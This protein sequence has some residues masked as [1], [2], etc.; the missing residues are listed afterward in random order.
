MAAMA[1]GGKMKLAFKG[2]P[3]PTPSKSKTLIDLETKFW[4]SMV[5]QDTDAALE[6]LEEPALMVSSH[7][8]MKFDHAGYRKMAEQ[9]SMVVTAFELSDVEA[10]F[11]NDK[12]AILTYR[13]RQEVAARG[14]GKSV[15]QEMNDTS[16]WVKTRDG[17]KCVMHTE[18]PACAG[19]EAH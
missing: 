16:T 9:G 19:A 8:A 14:N 7:G 5:D 18:T 4:Q 2:V 11:P 3:M 13:V 1:R 17:W 10:V 6:L 15:E 12:T